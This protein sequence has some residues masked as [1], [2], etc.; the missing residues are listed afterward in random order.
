MRILLPGLFMSLGFVQA[1]D[2]TVGTATARM[3]E[4]LEAVLC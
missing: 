2:V 4:K 1:A 3:G